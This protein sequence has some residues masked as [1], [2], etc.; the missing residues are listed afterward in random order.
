VHAALADD[1]QRRFTGAVRGGGGKE[2]D[3][4]GGKER[5]RSEAPRGSA[6]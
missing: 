1:L 3:K 5:R 4:E 6:K 2:S